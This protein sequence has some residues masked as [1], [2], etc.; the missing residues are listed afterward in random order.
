MEKQVNIMRISFDI[1]DTYTKDPVAF[2][3]LRALLKLAGHEVGVL[4]GRTPETVPGGPW[5][6]AYGGTEINDYPPVSQDWER[7]RGKSALMRKYKIDL[8]FDNA[9]G[10]DKDLCVIKI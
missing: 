1:D 3:R 8:H 6:F 4:S 10:F 9:D 7:S 2:Q 5:D